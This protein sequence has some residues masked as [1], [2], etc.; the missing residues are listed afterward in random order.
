MGRLFHLAGSL[1]A[2]TAATPATPRH[3]G[4]IAAVRDR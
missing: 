1:A 2:A 3:A 4:R